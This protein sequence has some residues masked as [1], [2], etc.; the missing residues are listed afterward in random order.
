MALALDEVERVESL[1]REAERL[2]LAVRTG[3]A[4]GL[5]AADAIE[6]QRQDLR[7]R[8]RLVTAESV[9]LEQAAH[10][11]AQQVIEKL[12]RVHRRQRRARSTHRP[13]D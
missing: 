13:T 2:D 1:R 7:R 9:V 5:G 12:K 6:E 10:V 8:E 4:Q 3:I 11:K